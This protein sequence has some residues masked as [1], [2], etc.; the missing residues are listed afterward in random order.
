MDTAPLW[1]EIDLSAIAHNIRELHRITQPQ[2]RLMA[3]VKANGYGHGAVE[4]AR[5]ALQNGASFLGVAR[6]EEGIHLREAG[7]DVPILVFGYT[8]PHPT[9]PAIFCNMISP[10]VSTPPQRHGNYPKPPHH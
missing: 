5:C 6:I 1:A 3:V 10:R 2:A 4:I 9:G 8:R 7:I